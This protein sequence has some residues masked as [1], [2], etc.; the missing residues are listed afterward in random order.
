MADPTNEQRISWPTRINVKPSA[1]D[2][3]REIA[4]IE[5]VPTATVVGRAVEGY[6]TTITRSSTS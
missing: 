1:R 3:I 5:R 4:K 6:V 2:A